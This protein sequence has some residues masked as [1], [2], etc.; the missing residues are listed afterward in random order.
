MDRLTDRAGYAMASAPRLKS[1]CGARCGRQ[2]D[3]ALVKTP[4]AVL[5]SRVRPIVAQYNSFEFFTKSDL[6]ALR[7]L[8]PASSEARETRQVEAAIKII[9]STVSCGRRR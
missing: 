7:P 8:L 3:A 9:A 6:T 5:W 1:L 4:L 2:R